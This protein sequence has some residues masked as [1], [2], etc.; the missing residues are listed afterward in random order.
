[1]T[2]PVRIRVSKLGI[3]GEELFLGLKR[4]QLMSV[5]HFLVKLIFNIYLYITQLLTSISHNPG[6][7]SDA[8]I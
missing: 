8:G 2:G 1:M 6:F 5:K 4:E 3:L 7:R